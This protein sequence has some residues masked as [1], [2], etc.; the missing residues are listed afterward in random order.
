MAW[1]WTD[2]LAELLMECDRVDPAVV[3]R[4]KSR[5]H[6]LRL[7][8]ADDPLALAR[9]LFADQSGDSARSSSATR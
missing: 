7:E 9:R 8:P 4:W 2:T 1:V 3:E 6:A 5:P